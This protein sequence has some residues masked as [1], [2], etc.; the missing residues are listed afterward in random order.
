MIRRGQREVDFIAVTHSFSEMPRRFFPFTSDIF[1][2]QTK[3]NLDVRR[4]V[5]QNYEDMKRIQAY[6]NQKARTNKHFF[7]HIKYE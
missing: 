2:F 4:G 3:D 6:V 7:T 5:L 1:L